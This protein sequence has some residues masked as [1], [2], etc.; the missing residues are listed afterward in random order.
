MIIITDQ[1]RYP[2]HW[3]AG[4]AD[5]NLPNRRRLARRGLTFERAFCNSSMCSPSRATLLTGLYPTQHGVDET[6]IASEGTLDQ[7][8]LRPATQNVAHVLASAG[9]DVQWRGKWHLSKDPTGLKSVRSPDDLDQY[10]FRGWLPPEGGQ[11]AKPAHFGGSSAAN[12]ARIAAEAVAFLDE[13]DSRSTRPFALFVSLINPHDIM[14]NPGLWRKDDYGEACPGC[15]DQGIRL[16]LSVNEDLERGFKP[17]AQAQSTTMWAQW[18]GPITGRQASLDYV[19]LYAFLHKESDR[20]IGAV[21]DALESRPD[22]HRKTI[23][24]HLADHGEMGLAHG[25]MRQK[26]YNAYEETIHVPFVIANPVLFPGPSRTTAL[27]SLIDVLPTLATL[28]Q[29]PDRDRWDFRGLDLTPIIRDAV[30]HPQGPAA[31]VQDCVVFSSDERLDPDTVTAPS[32]VRC[33]READ[34][35]VVMYLDPDGAQE[36]D[37]ELYDLARDPFELRNMADPRSPYFDSRKTAEMTAKLERRLAET[38]VGS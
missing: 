22:L 6:L 26:A 36:P 25:G 14:A 10:G 12:D 9:Y 1:E 27:V 11:D 37:H 34:W 8:P 20:H 38:S 15:F 28:A 35:K 5:A 32:H 7:Q 3:P 16:P 31:T 29:V 21:L 13:A 24:I 4:W 30:E 2:Q 18:L 23:V 17:A 19:N 33:L